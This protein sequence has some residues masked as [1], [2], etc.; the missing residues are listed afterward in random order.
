MT[1]YLWH[2]PAL[3]FMHQSSTSAIRAGRGRIQ[4]HAQH[5]ATTH[6]GGLVRRCFV[7]LRPLEQSL[8]CGGGCVAT[9]DLRSAVGVLLCI[10][11]AAAGFGRLGPQGPGLYCVAVMLAFDRCPYDRRHRSAG[12][13]ASLP[14]ST[15]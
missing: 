8:R 14:A 1:L 6:H 11:G 3:L 2:I 9:T 13:A 15:R 5:P 4:L 12:L 10:A 7:M